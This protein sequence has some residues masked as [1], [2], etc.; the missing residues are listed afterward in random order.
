MDILDAIQWPS[1]GGDGHRC[2]D[3]GLSEKVQAQL[4]VLGV[5]SEQRVMDRLGPA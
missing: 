3:G 5:S 2:V 1:D 4:G